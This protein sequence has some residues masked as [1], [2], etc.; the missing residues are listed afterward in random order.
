MG[1]NKI[2][3]F[4]LIF[5]LIVFFGC[6]QE[7]KN[8]SGNVNEEQCIQVPYTEQVPKQVQIPY[9][10]QECNPV[11]YTEQECETQKLVYNF[12]IENPVSS[13]PSSMQKKD[14]LKT[15]FF[16]CTKETP[17]YC[18]VTYY[19]CKITITNSDDK[20]G[21]W[22]ISY[23]V[24]GSDGREVEISIEPEKRTSVPLTVMPRQTQQFAWSFDSG[25]KTTY[26]EAKNYWGTKCY[27]QFLSEPTKQVCNGVLK[28]K[29]ECNNVTKY[30]TETQYETV[31]KYKEECS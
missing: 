16:I 30:R 29:Q 7:N 27:L 11:T 10:E 12:T 17:T 24:I 1:L 5:L 21:T 31:T 20:Q 19:N 18:T 14:C 13:C 25:I 3:L 28:T 8:E 15:D 22:H 26:N 23:G 6:A 2:F 4:T 9:T